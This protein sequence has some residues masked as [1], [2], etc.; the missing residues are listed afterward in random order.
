MVAHVENM[1]ALDLKALDYVSI[2]FGTNDFTSKVALDNPEDLYDI[3]TF[4]GALRYSLDKLFSA[5]PDLKIMLIT[6]MYRDRQSK[7][8]DDPLITDGKNSDDYPN[9][10][11]VYLTEYGDKIKEIAAGYG[12][13]GKV[14]DMY[15]KSGINR[16]NHQKYFYD[17]LHPSSSTGS[18]GNRLLGSKFSDFIVRNF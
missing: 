13:N 3:T 1:K 7:T 6:P 11:G 16:Y 17:G 18:I 2:W 5:N 12:Q 9:G 8:S 14:L 15:E 10:A 4:G